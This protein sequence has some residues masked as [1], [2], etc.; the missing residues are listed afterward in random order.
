WNFKG[1]CFMVRWEV[2]KY[3]PDFR[4]KRFLRTE[5]RHLSL[6]F[7][8]FVGPD[9][10]S[11]QRDM[12]EIGKG[13]T[14]G[15]LALNVQKRLSRA[16]EKVGSGTWCQSETGSLGSVQ[17]DSSSLNWARAGLGAPRRNGRGFSRL[18]F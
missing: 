11:T 2:C 12:A 6:W 17:S 18:L 15:K 16:Q 4:I 9:T 14:A 7:S 13:V 1:F 8:P 3:L 10:T 5:E